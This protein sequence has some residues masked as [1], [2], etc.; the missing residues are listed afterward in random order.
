[1]GLYFSKKQACDAFSTQFL[2]E[3]YDELKQMK[4]NFEIVFV[5][6]DEKETDFR[7]GF[8][9]M[10]WLAVPF[11]EENIICRKLKAGLNIQTLP[12]LHIIGPHGKTW[13]P[14]GVEVIRDTGGRAYPFTDRKRAQIDE[15]DERRRKKQKLKHLLVSNDADFVMTKEGDVVSTSK[16]RPLHVSLNCTFS[17]LSLKMSL[18]VG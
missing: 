17:K 14:D 13:I 3:R 5:S 16:N 12:K 2:A 1:M 7:H 11:Q 9:K 4:G 18:F 10:P 6:Q 15:I 8:A